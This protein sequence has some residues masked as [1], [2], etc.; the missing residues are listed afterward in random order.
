[1]L[2]RFIR[3]V[4]EIKW[5]GKGKYQRAK[6]AAEYAWEKNVKNETNWER[7]VCRIINEL[8]NMTISK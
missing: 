1:M 7:V 6:N 3:N 4:N 8:V 2:A 5:K